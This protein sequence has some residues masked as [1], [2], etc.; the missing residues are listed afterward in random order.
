MRRPPTF[1]QLQEPSVNGKSEYSE[2]T[3]QTIDAE[4]RRLLVSAYDHAREILIEDR[5][6]L[7]VLARRL[8]EKEVVDRE[9]LRA[10]L[11]QP[12]E[13]PGEDARPNVGHVP[14]RAD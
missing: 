7:E 11:G 3:A 4:V 12:R 10:L 6:Y 1:L 8:L 13:Q 2:A 9:E 14:S 5:G